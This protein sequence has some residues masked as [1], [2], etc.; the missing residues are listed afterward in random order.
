[1]QSCHGLLPVAIHES[2][3]EDL[4]K[5]MSHFLIRIHSHTHCSAHN[6]DTQYTN[7]STCFP[8]G[9]SIIIQP[10]QQAVLITIL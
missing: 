3:T 2:G 5:R 10:I 1:M 7:N 8:H 6:D 9:R 4:P